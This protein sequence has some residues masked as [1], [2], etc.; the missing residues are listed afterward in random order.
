M[1]RLV[2]CPQQAQVFI[3]L[4]ALIV[5]FHFTESPKPNVTPSLMKMEIPSA[6]SRAKRNLQSLL[7]LHLQAGMRYSFLSFVVWSSIALMKICTK[8]PVPMGCQTNTVS[9]KK[10]KMITRFWKV[11]WLEVLVKQRLKLVSRN[12]LWIPRREKAQERRRRHCPKIVAGENSAIASTL[13]VTGTVLTGWKLEDGL[14]V[15]TNWKCTDA[16]RL[17]LML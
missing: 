7:L 11:E 4:S 5:A 2:V 3:R 15:G 8:L 13:K 16:M 14:L 12:K 6:Q 10:A 17:A 1:W 9:H